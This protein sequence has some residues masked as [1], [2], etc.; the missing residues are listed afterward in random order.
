MT[1]K[2][3]MQE[4]IKGDYIYQEGEKVESIFFVK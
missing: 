1:K 4:Y 3:I 2:I